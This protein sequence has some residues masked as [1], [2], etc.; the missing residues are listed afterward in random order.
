MKKRKLIIFV[1]GVLCFLMLRSQYHYPPD[2][3]MYLNAYNYIVA[4]S[5]F[6]EKSINVSNKLTGTSYMFFFSEFKENNNMVSLCNLYTKLYEL[7]EKYTFKDS[8]YNYFDEWFVKYTQSDNYTR[9]DTVLA[10]SAIVNH[11]LFADVYLGNYND[12]GFG[13]TVFYYFSFDLNS[14][15]KSVRKLIGHGL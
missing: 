7:D 10:F 9:A 5:F 15:I 1:L 12:K 2:R 13:E 8:I 3:I 6:I 4:D 11:E 14:N